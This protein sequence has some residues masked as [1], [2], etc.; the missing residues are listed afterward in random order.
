[1]KLLLSVAVCCLSLF[2]VSPVL[3]QAEHLSVQLMR[4]TCRV[5]GPNTAGT[6][7]LLTR[8]VAGNPQQNQTVL[9]TA[10]HVFEAMQGEQATLLCRQ[11]E[12]DGTYKK[13]PVPLTIRKEKQPLWTKHPNADVAAL[14]VK[15][16]EAADVAGV[17][18]ELLASDDLLKQYDIHAGDEV[19]CLGFPHQF[20]NNQAAFPV[21]RT[22]LISSLSVLPTKTTQSLLVSYNTFEGDSGGPVYMAE[23]NRLVEGNPQPQNVRLI[24]GLVHGQHFLDEDIRTPYEVRK[25]R[26]RLGLAIVIHASFI[27]ETIEKLPAPGP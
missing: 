27:R 5:S 8:P 21:L 1:M 9:I 10:A 24:L 2:V 23:S 14:A 25:V 18:V 3:V 4:A 7:L 6:A 19:F 15:L 13:L 20:E 11:K 12:P 17:P 22:G 16:P 26:H